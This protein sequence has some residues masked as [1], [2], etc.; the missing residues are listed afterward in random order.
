MELTPA[1]DDRFDLTLRAA[2]RSQA[3]MWFWARGLPFQTVHPEF[4]NIRGKAVH[5]EGMFRWDADKKRSALSFTSPLGGDPAL[6]LRVS[7]D[8][9]DERWSDPA[10]DFRLRKIEA[11]VHFHAAPSG[12]WGWTTGGSVSNR[13]FSNSLASGLG[14][15]YS[16]AISKTWVRD[17]AR[18]LN[19]SSSLQVE[20][21]KLWGQKSERFAKSIQTTRVQWGGFT[22]DVRIGGVIGLVPFDERFVVGL[23]RDTDLWLRAHPATVDGRKNAANT[24]RSFIVTNSDFQKTIWRTPW[25]Q[26][27]SGPFL[28]AGR[29]STRWLLDVGVEFRLNVLQSVGLSVSYGKSLSDGSRSVFVR[30][31]KL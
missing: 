8:G 25:L 13:T 31:P 1:A 3:N 4:S 6:S 17:A 24:S 10:G 14:L 22:S 12:R 9:R 18:D 16:G 7:G 26:L 2:E 11:G 20:G 15:K 29:F 19:L 27:R 5:L 21:G 30:Q 23:E 28:D